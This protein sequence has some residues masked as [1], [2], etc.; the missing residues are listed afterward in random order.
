MTSL[1]LIQLNYETGGYNLLARVI[2]NGK[3]ALMMVDTSEPKTV[4]DTDHLQKFV[5]QTELKRNARRNMVSPTSSVYTY[6]ATIDKLEIGSVIITNYKAAAVDLSQIN[7][8]FR[9]MGNP[10]I[11]GLLGCDV[12][13]HCKAV[14]RFEDRV[15]ELHAL[16]EPGEVASNSVIE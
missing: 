10:Q 15:L 1:K 16:E 6:I 3:P 4:L 12:L 9:G 7:R 14:I 11:D 2:I 5:N 8:S 13:R